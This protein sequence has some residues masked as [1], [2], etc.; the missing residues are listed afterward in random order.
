MSSQQVPNLSLL[1]ALVFGLLLAL[2]ATFLAEFATH[3]AFWHRINTATLPAEARSILSEHPGEP[4]SPEQWR[5]LDGVMA[6]NG[7]WPGGEELLGASVR[8]S[9]YWFL[10]LPVSLAALLRW[11]RRLSAPG[12]ALLVA[13][14]LLLLAYAFARGSASLL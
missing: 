13:P 14:S 5:R 2:F 4:I 11:R 1:K 6:R 7:G 10:V 9:W 8:H 3:P 12:I